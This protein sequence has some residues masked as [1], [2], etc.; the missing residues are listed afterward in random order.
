MKI[1]VLGAA[2]GGGFPQWNCN[3]RNCRGVRDG[4]LRAT[5]RTQSSLAVM[6]ADLNAAVLINASPDIRAQLLANSDLQPARELRDSALNAVL[7]MDAQIDH[8]TG[9]LLLRE[10][11]APL[12]VWCTDSVYGD[13]TRENPILQVLAHYCGANRRRVVPGEPFSIDAVRGVRFTALA[14]SSKAPPF[15]PN[16][17]A[18]VSGDN[19][20]LAIENAH[21]G[22][23][24]FYAPGLGTLDE[25]VWEQMLAAD[26]VLVDGTFW[27]DD[28]MIAQ[29]L[30]RKT[31]R[32]MGH[33][34]L[35]G[36]GGMSGGM[37]EW[38]DR[39]PDGTRKIVTH[40]NNT[41]PILDEDSPELARL[42]EH[43]IEVAY[44]GMEIEL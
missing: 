13:L 35:A 41:N 6:G 21:S 11:A 25:S 29:G 33:L 44:D 36:P 22:A 37:I 16:R 42:I 9:L 3:C 18:P 5:A 34:P 15:S 24:M 10:S 12:Q 7:L 32:A 27:A 40:I 23:S 28:E 17:H 26:C 30:S 14:L 43:G 8:T 38:L 39:L 4:T 31:A 19:I 2:A 20:G 1:R